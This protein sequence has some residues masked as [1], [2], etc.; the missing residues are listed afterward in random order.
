VVAWVVGLRYTDAA[1]QCTSLIG[2]VIAKRR[3]KGSL[4]E[5][6]YKAVMYNTLIDITRYGHDCR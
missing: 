1:V 3:E 6:R 4:E 5:G 2:C